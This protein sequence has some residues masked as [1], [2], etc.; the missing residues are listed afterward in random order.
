MI[1]AMI[2]NLAANSPVG[3]IKLSVDALDNRAIVIGMEGMA[4]I[5]QSVYGLL[6]NDFIGFNLVS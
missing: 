1:I 3:C 5:N 2:I 6:N 4:R